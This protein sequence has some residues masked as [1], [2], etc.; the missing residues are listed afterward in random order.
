MP[1][2]VFKSGV[3]APKVY[4]EYK[5]GDHSIGFWVLNRKRATLLSKIQARKIAR[6]EKAEYEK[7]EVTK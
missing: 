7:V 5:G 1:Y 2:I 6:Q 4:L 3:V